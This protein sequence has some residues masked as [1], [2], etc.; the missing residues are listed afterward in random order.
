M[1]SIESRIAANSAKY[2][3]IPLIWSTWCF[4]IPAHAEWLIQRKLNYQRSNLALFFSNLIPVQ[5]IL[6]RKLN[7]PKDK[8]HLR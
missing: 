7:Y 4:S 1:F 3:T 5:G 2:K 8:F 6:K